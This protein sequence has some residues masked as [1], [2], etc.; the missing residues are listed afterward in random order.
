M[1]SAQSVLNDI[2]ANKEAFAFLLSIAAKNESQGGWENARIAA[3]TLDLDLA[4]KIRRHGDDETRHGRLFAALLSRHGLNPVEV[5]LEADYCRLLERR[6]I[7]LAH[8]RLAEDRP[9]DDEEIIVYLAHSRVTEQ[10]SAEEIALLREAFAGDPALSKALALVAGDEVN[11][12][13]YCHEELLRLA[14]RGHSALVRRTLKA[15]AIAEIAVYRQVSLAFVRRIAAI[16][17]WP[18]AKTALLI[19]GIDAVYC[20]ERCATWRRMVRLVLPPR[21]NALFTPTEPLPTA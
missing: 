20:L 16:L 5:P 11:H 15:Y 7:G 6:G 3:L 17:G 2:R 18:A 19:F 14:A 12:L 9:L 8:A 10:R 21:R 13:Y 1:L 4:A